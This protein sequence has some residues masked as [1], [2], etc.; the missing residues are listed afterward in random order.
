MTPTQKA[1]RVQARTGGQ[2]ARETEA[3]SETTTPT[4]AEL[5]EL[6]ERRGLT[7]GAAARHLA[8]STGQSAA[9]WQVALSEYER[10]RRAPGPD[11]L[12]ALLAL[13]S[14]EPDDACRQDVAEALRGVTPL[15]GVH[16]VERVQR[17]L[18]EYV[19]M[20]GLVAAMPGYAGRR[21]RTS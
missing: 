18:T 19:A 7:Q 21:R 14:P 8:A 5:R 12:A 17:V 9:A 10:D 2:V 11:R 15:V 13:Y 20:L 1:P 4:G 3:T 16:G 6:R